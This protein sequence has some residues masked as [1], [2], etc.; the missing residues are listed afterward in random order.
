MMFGV[1]DVSVF[2]R[3]NCNASL[4]IWREEIEVRKYCVRRGE[5]PLLDI[6]VSIDFIASTSH[7]FK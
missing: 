5:T 6:F 1:R 3:E 2:W 7:L 4:E